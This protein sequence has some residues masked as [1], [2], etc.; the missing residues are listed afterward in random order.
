[1]ALFYDLTGDGSLG[2]FV[3]VFEAL[4]KIVDSL[5]ELSYHFL[6][7]YF[8]PFVNFSQR[9][10]LLIHQLHVV[11]HGVRVNW[12]WH[13]Q[14]TEISHTVGCPVVVDDVSVEHQHNHIELQEDL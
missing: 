13:A 12:N 7:H 10:S 1:M 5:V 14:V 11:V 8:L 3:R 4:N 6:I 2:R 9:N